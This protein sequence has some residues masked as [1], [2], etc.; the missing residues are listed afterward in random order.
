MPA[1]NVTSIAID[2]GR[3]FRFGSSARFDNRSL[4]LNRAEVQ[5]TGTSGP[6]SGSLTY[7]YLRTPQYYYN[8]LNNTLGLRR[9]EP[10]I[11]VGCCRPL[12]CSR[13][14]GV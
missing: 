5:A 11:R 13:C 14:V 6:L 9:F 12:A 8:L 7:A 4:A 2:T 1:E 3:G 10:P